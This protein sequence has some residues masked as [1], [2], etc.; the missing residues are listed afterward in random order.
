MRRRFTEGNRL[1]QINDCVMITVFRKIF[2]QRNGL[3]NLQTNLFPS[4]NLREPLITNNLLWFQFV[5]L[6]GGVS[7]LFICFFFSF[8]CFAQTSRYTTESKAAIRNYENGLHAYDARDFEKAIKE[9]QQSINKD[10]NFVEAYIL[11]ASVYEDTGENEKAI[12]QY[13]K[14]FAVNESFFPNNYIRVAALE[15]KTGKYEEAKAHYEKYLMLKTNS[16]EMQKRAQ[17]GIANCRFAHKAIKH[18]VPFNPVNLGAGINTSESEYYASL[19]IDQKEIIFT[20]DIKDANSPMGHQEDFYISSIANNKWQ[21]A[22][23]LG[24]PLNTVLNEGGPSI[25]ADG[26]ILFFTACDREGGKGSC[27]IYLAQ[28]NSDNNW[29]KAINLGTPV[30]TGAWETQPSFSSDGKTLYFI[31]GTYDRSRRMQQD[32]YY[33]VF[34]TDRTWSEPKALINKINTP[35]REESVFIHPDNQTLYFSSDG[36][37]GMGGMDIYLSRRDTNG[38]WGEPVNLGYP[39]NT[40]GDENSLIV[41]PDGKIAFFSS[42]RTG[43]FGGLDLYSF[44][45]Y[46]AARPLTVSYVK[47]HVTDAS[48]NENLA[49]GFEIIDVESGKIIVSN[50]TDKKRGEFLASLPS[51]KN[52]MLNVNKEG[53]LFYSDYFECKNASDEQHAFVLDI[54][55]SKPKAGEHVVLKNVFFDVN[56]FDLKKESTAEL[57]KLIAFLK[58]NPTSK[59]EISGH[60]DNTGDKTT[61]QKLSENRAKAV[62]DFLISQNIPV[63]RLTFKGYGDAKPITS[64]D[65]AEG[66]A[67]NRRTEFTIISL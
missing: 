14:S 11:L 57:N 19:T 35:G 27:D 45:L 13:N 3:H 37:T 25:S 66:K 62:Y 60:T 21:P 15:I 43:G 5:G 1:E 24:A 39:I 6:R 54:K 46:E 10:E 49:A 32:I 12:E 22:K 40:S 8:S 36:H 50:T 4:V 53:Y 63:S 34:Q 31:R 44:D 61:N 67:Q 59:I 51:G 47:A 58:N 7:F 20:R 65:T 64:N 38:E 18:P 33:S 55:L 29:T 42:D 30:N 28:R 56:K 41:S 16:I 52:Y 48:T 9:L 17:Q 23:N 2:F 26:R